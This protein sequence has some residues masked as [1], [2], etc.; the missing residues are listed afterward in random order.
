MTITYPLTPKAP[1]TP[2]GSE[3]YRVS[4]V[5]ALDEEARQKHN[6]AREELPP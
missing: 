2:A 3:T 5:L 1:T 4:R 6:S